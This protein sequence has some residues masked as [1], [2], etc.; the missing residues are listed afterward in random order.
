MI[1]VAEPQVATDANAD[2]DADA[3]A[4][5][6]ASTPSH[7][8]QPRAGATPN[9]YLGASAQGG[10]RALG[11]SLIALPPSSR[12]APDS[13][14]SS[15]PFARQGS[16]LWRRL[17]KQ[18]GLLTTARFA[19]ALG[20]RE[21]RAAK[22]LGVPARLVGH[23]PLVEA[24][25]HLQQ[26]A[27]AAAATVAPGPSASSSRDAQRLNA[28]AL[29]EANF[30]AGS[31][32][33]DAGAAWTTDDDES[34]AGD[35]AD[36]SRRRD[37]ESAQAARCGPVGVAMSWGLAQEWAS[38]YELKQLFPRSLI[39]ESGLR[40]VD[41]KRIQ[42]AAAP[43]E[44]A[45]TAPLPP[46]GASPDAIIAHAV[47]LDA[48]SALSLLQ[49]WR[50]R[51]PPTLAEALRLVGADE[52]DEER[53]WSVAAPSFVASA[54]EDA[55]RLV[56]RRMWHDALRLVTV[57]ADDTTE[58]DD[59][60][61]EAAAAGDGGGSSAAAAPLARE[62]AAAAALLDAL[63][64]PGELSSPSAFEA[65]RRRSSLLTYDEDDDQEEERAA[66]RALLERAITAEGE[67]NQ[68]PLPLPA[69]CFV[70][71]RRRGADHD[72]AP[73][74]TT[75]LGR[76]LLREAVEIKNASPFRGVSSSGGGGG[77]GN[78]KKKKKGEKFRFCL[79]D[80]GPRD[81]ILALWTPQ[82]QLH[83]LA[84]GLPSLLLMQRSA[85]RGAVVW[86]VSR[87]DAWLGKA[88]ALVRRLMA[89]WVVVGGGGTASPPHDCFFDDPGYGPFLAHTRRAALGAVRVA[90]TRGSGGVLS[91]EE[92]EE[93]EAVAT[94]RRRRRRCA[95]FPADADRRFFV[96]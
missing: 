5:A 92:E 64:A 94:R 46:M 53:L 75:P 33:D 41:P 48:K 17:R 67:E 85:T 89:R 28:Q 45:E 81:A 91:D 23:A 82:A 25:R 15:A 19:D 66:Y 37:A 29:W 72:P 51:L 88:M 42:T 7:H 90:E 61:E 77:G 47:R 71:R 1:A 79:N 9:L 87:D 30:G 56:A 20:L 59:D 3:T 60:E 32:D 93:E 38:L 74:P 6:R 84:T 58:E 83:C 69:C 31:H 39:E 62:L 86:R 55:A 78:Q 65:A 4:D 50:A 11:R 73:P 13:D 36:R 80:P 70:A 22:S 95:R 2:A 26:G 14:S 21:P 27:Q 96:D 24:C 16:E 40:L 12:L 8:H 54:G 43:E 63:L 52:E 10:R 68:E 76:L 57:V 34:D 18:G 49:Q 44:E 35:G